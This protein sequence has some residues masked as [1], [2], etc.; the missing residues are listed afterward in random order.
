MHSR[1]E[2]ND[3]KFKE[4]EYKYQ[5]P[6]NLEEKPMFLFWSARDLVIVIFG[7]MIG[8]YMYLSL[9]TPIPI[10]VVIC[11]LVLTMQIT[12]DSRNLWQYIMSVFHYTSNPMEWIYTQDNTADII[13]TDKARVGRSH[14]KK[15]IQ[16]KEN[17]PAHERTQ[18]TVINKE[19]ELHRKQA[20]KEKIRYDKVKNKKIE[21]AKKKK[22]KE[23]SN[24]SEAS[25][26]KKSL[27]EVLS[28]SILP[29]LIVIVIVILAAYII[30]R[31]YF[32]TPAKEAANNIELN[33]AKSTDISWYS[34]T[35]DPLDYIDYSNSTSGIKVTAKPSEIDTTVL[36]TVDVKY[37]IEDK[38]G[39]KMTA[40]REYNIVDNELP[41]ITLKSDHLDLNINDEFDPAS[42]IESVVD[43]IDGALS[44]A[45]E[46]TFGCYTIASD[47]DTSVVGD[48]TV[49]I[50]AIDSNGNEATSSYTVTVK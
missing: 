19:A 6:N 16:R 32:V 24:Y 14:N 48:Y 4:E 27:S 15:A 10:A 22:L 40:T 20:E 3:L 26:E 12:G 17:K 35:V 13:E 44:K 5:Y 49:Q 36:G 25:N 34:G 47:V 8:L 11:Y 41:I 2:A 39:N 33:Y 46:S 42:N 38:D 30:L 43:R 7:G 29:I 1:R 50:S 9:G 21:K 31:G 28:R 23:I 18:K 45:D 37:T